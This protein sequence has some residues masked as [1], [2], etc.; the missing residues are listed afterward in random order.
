MQGVKVEISKEEYMRYKFDPAQ[1]RRERKETIPQVWVA[2]YGWY[3][4]ECHESN[5]H[6]YRV[7]QIGDSC[8]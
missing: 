5:G 8:D 3:G 1:Y 7:D 2:G 6:Y 4:V